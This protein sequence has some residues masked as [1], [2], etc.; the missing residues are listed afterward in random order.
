MAMTVVLSRGRSQPALA[1][2]NQI[3]FVRL[4]MS[5][6]PW[7]TPPRSRTGRNSLRY[8]DQ[9][10][11]VEGSGRLG[12]R[13]PLCALETAPDAHDVCAQGGMADERRDVGAERQ[14][15]EVAHVLAQRPPLLGFEQWADHV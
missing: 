8:S 13:R 6:T 12:F 1:S 14:R 15:V 2:R 10:A 11:K 9:P 7:K 4:V 3:T 5:G